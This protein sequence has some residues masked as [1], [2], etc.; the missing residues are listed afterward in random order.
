MAN[1]TKIE[2]RL[3][4]VVEKI[5]PNQTRRYDLLA[6]KTGQARHKWVNWMNRRQGLSL[7]MLEAF[8]ESWPDCANWIAT[9]AGVPSFLK[10]DSP[11]SNIEMKRDEKGKPITNVLHAVSRHKKGTPPL[12]EWG[13]T[14]TGPFELAMNILYHFGLEEPEAD[15][16]STHFA[17]DVISYVPN[18]GGVITEQQVREWLDQ[19]AEEIEEQI[20]KRK[21]YDELRAKHEAEVKAAMNAFPRSKND[22]QAS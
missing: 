1:E 6:E 18:K 4:D 7:E 15:Y 14:G 5:A 3:R 19:K 10:S 20:S 17:R 8:L 22:N 11:L 2:T 21:L 12:F 13:Y 9:G 16:F